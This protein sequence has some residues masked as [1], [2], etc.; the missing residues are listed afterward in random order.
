MNEINS[1]TSFG[2]FIVNIITMIIAVTSSLISYLVYKEN[3]S[4]DVIVYLEQDEQTRTLLNLVIKNI[5]K[6]AARDVV[7]K[8]SKSMPL[9]AF[10]GEQKTEMND[11]PLIKGIPFLAPG[12]SRRL[13]IGNYGGINEWLG[14]D[15]VEIEYT[16]YK[17]NSRNMLFKKIK[18]IS[19]LDIYS[20]TGVSAADNSTGAK[21][22]HSL[23][24]IEK[25]ILSKK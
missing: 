8:T 18:N 5:G 11:G 9:K 6:S 1:Y 2:G 23:S 19:Y 25:A 22:Q 3:S 15:K 10:K 21:I 24:K 16:F 4:P 14:N 12:S 17:A 7:F 13:I 20:F